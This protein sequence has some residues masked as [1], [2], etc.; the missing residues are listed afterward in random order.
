M[1]VSCGISLLTSE[2]LGDTGR[3]TAEAKTA[4]HRDT[5]S[6]KAPCSVRQLGADA[7]DG[8]RE[9][10]LGLC[11]SSALPQHQRQTLSPLVVTCGRLHLRFPYLF[12]IC[13]VLRRQLLH[14]THSVLVSGKNPSGEGWL[15]CDAQASQQMCG[16][17]VL[18]AVNM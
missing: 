13:L 7:T 9:P 6:P 3:T 8:G 16:R 12:F 5:H 17:I 14:S 15:Q 1:H 4:V 18:A 2:G 11:A 10:A